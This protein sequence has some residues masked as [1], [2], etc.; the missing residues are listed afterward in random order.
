MENI[1]DAALDEWRDWETS[2]AQWLLLDSNYVPDIAAQVWV[3]DVVANEVVVATY[4]R[5]PVTNPTRTVDTTQHRVTYDCDDPDFGNLD[6]GPPGI[7][8]L[9]LA[10]TGADDASSLLLAIY[11]LGVIGTGPVRPILAPTGVY[12]LEQG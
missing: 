2:P 6:K 4:T 10:K 8:T 1:F 11:T 5:E 3:S 12:W 7:G 9:C